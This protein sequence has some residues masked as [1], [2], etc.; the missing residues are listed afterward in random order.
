MP[1]LCRI[2]AGIGL[3]TLVSG[4]ANIG[5]ITGYENGDGI[6]VTPSD[7]GQLDASVTDAEFGDSTDTSE[8]L[9]TDSQGQETADT[10]STDVGAVDTGGDAAVVDY[11]LPTI[12]SAC[13]R[14]QVLAYAPNGYAKLLD[15]LEADSTA[16]A[17]YFIHV[18]AGPTDKTQPVGAAVP[19]AIR[20]RHGRFHAVA[21][22]N[23]TAW[24]ASSSMTWLEKGVEFRNRMDKAGYNVA[25]GDTWAIIELPATVRTDAALRGN[26]RDLLHGLH[27]GVVG[28]TPR[29]GFTLLP[30]LAQSTN[31][32]SLPQFRT[33]CETFLSDAAF[34]TEVGASTIGFGQEA[35][36]DPSKTCVSGATIAAL[37]DH[38][39]SFAEYPAILA[40]AGPVGAA[41][42]RTTLAATYFPVL[43]AAYMSPTYLT[44]SLPLAQMEAFASLQI[45]ATR[46]FA[47]AN[48][49]PGRRLGFVWDEGAA[50]PLPTDLSAVAKRLAAAIHAAYDP[51]GTPSFAC[52]PTGATTS[53]MCQAG[54]VFN[55]SWSM[56]STW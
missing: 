55:D 16:C 34:W 12:P 33:Q 37:S 27:V 25:R 40:A 29:A 32:L 6:D 5:G 46:A 39:N 23:W 45:Y 2:I 43:N 38:V 10:G 50:A 26:V 1:K 56:Y 15:A 17:D 49:T 22:F 36:L 53:C 48:P 18:A 9:S 19:N 51:T 28:A 41:T 35:W 20:A 52:S 31:P 47:D 8:A 4:C 44:S 3:S 42:A 24:S 14:A 54:G 13:S 11:P 21:E 30:S 7:T